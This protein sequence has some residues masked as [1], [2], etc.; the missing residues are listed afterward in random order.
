MHP[1]T[2]SRAVANKYA[3]IPHGVFELR[4]QALVSGARLLQ[5]N[6]Q[7]SG[8]AG[9]GV[10]FLGEL[11]YPIITR[12]VA[13]VTRL[14]GGINHQPHLA[15]LA[16]D[17]EDGFIAYR[18]FGRINDIPAVQPLLPEVEHHKQR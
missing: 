3:H 15:E 8:G 14:I 11:V 7:P 2:V 6:T 4:T 16:Q 12:I 9:R 18:V 5:A 10:P 17:R 1:S 13:E